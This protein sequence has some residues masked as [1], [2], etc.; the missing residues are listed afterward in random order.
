MRQFM[1]RRGMVEILSLPLDHRKEGKALRLIL[2]EEKRLFV[3]PV[4][5]GKTHYN[6]F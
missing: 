3:F 1:L 6:T 5:Q 2:E 4:E